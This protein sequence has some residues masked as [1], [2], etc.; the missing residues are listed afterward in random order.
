MDAARDEG[1]HAALQPYHVHRSRVG[2]ETG[3][4]PVPQLAIAVPA[5]ALEG[6]SRG[7]RAGVLASRSDVGHVI[8]Q[9]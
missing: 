8:I 7:Q 1:S 2:S 4:G 5:P 6:A 3:G 9:A